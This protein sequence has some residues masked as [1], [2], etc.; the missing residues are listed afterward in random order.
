MTEPPLCPDCRRLALAL[1][2]L[3]T[4]QLQRT[5]RLYDAP[6]THYV[7]ASI[8][9]TL[10]ALSTG[11]WDRLIA[12]SAT[13]PEQRAAARSRLNRRARAARH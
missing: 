5:G 12:G 11:E 2:A 4:I 9:K 8:R 10:C 6:E 13:D 3:T 7:P 1:E